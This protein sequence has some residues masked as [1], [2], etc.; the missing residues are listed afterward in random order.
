M[1]GL[2]CGM[3]DLAPRQGIEPGSPAL[4]AWSPNHWTTT[5]VL[6]ISIF[7]QRRNN[8][9][10]RGYATIAK[11]VYDK[12]ANAKEDLKP[13]MLCTVG[14]FSRVLLFVTGSTVPYQA[15]LSM[16]FPRQEYWCRVPT[17]SSSES[18]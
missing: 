17:L 16:G 13:A 2:S 7:N 4:G 12:M 3:K 11:E 10:K 9:D 14:R 18:S 5:E 1:L 15:P 6:P 8:G